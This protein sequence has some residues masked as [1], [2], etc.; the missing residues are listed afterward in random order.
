MQTE[1][2][3]SIGMPVYNR[4]EALRKA[5]DSL[6]NQSYRNLEI[7]ISN[8]SPDNLEVVAI[9]EEYS[10][11]D[12]RIKCTHQKKNI[13]VVA[14]FK[15]V[16]AKASSD[17]FMWASDDDLWGESFI[18]KGLTFLLKNTQYKAWFCTVNNIDSY[19]REIR[20]Y[21]GFSRFTSSKSKTK[22]IIKY[23]FE[24]EILG[25]ANIIYS[26][27]RIKE[28]NKVIDSYFINNAWG[29][30]M[31][32]NL[33]FLSKYRIF[34]S[35]EVLLQ[36][37]VDEK[38]G[39]NLIKPVFLSIFSCHLPHPSKFIR[40]LMEYFNAIK[41]TKY[42]YLVIIIILIRLIILPINY[43]FLALCRFRFFFK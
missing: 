15:F 2:L 24:P 25:K 3:V 5:L 4:T 26:I 37:R 11:K 19:D 32:F 18:Q 39:K 12:S 17:Y 33:S 40:Y 7:I 29:S 31:C 6:L 34:L 14:N 23:L 43:I 28:L 41:T 36:K 35:D 16:L 42:R 20:K 8:N 30:D 21:N 10:S 27:Y 9:L 38:H 13:G 22:D 1:P